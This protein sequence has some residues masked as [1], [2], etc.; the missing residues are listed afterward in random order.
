VPNEYSETN[1]SQRGEV[2]AGALELAVAVLSRGIRP[3]GSYEGISE[4]D[5]Q[6]YQWRTIANW[7]ALNRAVLSPEFEPS[8]EGG[9]E[10]D[11]SFVD[12]RWIKFTK[13]WAAGYTFGIVGN[14]LISL[15]ATPLQ[16][17]IRWILVNRLF[18]DDV[19]LLGISQRGNESR[20]VIAQRDVRGIAPT[21]GEIEK[22]FTENLGMRRLKTPF[23]VGGYGARAYCRGRIAVF[24]VRPLNC[25]R[26]QSGIVVP[27]DVIPCLFGS[28]GAA[29]LKRL[30]T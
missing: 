17:L 2:K 8:R 30:S 19:E 26:E 3:D 24:D 27:I 11:L 15:P 9:R 29:V 25:V 10:H 1:E 28:V 20:L 18:G 5:E 21:W 23:S 4:G 14:E 13:P 7:A 6:S 16:Y 12:G 22:D